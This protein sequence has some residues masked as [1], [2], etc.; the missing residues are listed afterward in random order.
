MAKSTYYFEISKSDVV[1]ERN[2][3]ILC[4]IQSIF[5]ENKRR[6][7]VRRSSSR[8]GKSRI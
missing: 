8:T 2:E 3:E 1:A 7:G 4:E 5:A 6:Y